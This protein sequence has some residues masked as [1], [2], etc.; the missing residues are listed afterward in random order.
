MKEIQATRALLPEC[1]IS[2]AKRGSEFSGAW[3]GAACH[4]CIRG[5]VR[6]DATNIEVPGT[7]RVVNLGEGPCNPV[8]R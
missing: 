7:S 6:L 3:A 4:A 5:V 8:T 2:H 1:T